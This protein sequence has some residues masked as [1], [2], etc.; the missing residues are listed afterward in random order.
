MGNRD[1]IQEPEIPWNFL[2]ITSEMNGFQ[3]TALLLAVVELR[4]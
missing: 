4:G 3:T 2:L 1:F